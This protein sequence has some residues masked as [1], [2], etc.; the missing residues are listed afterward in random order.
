MPIPSTSTVPFSPPNR[1]DPYWIKGWT[2]QNPEGVLSDA[3]TST[4]LPDDITIVTVT[5]SYVDLSGRFFNSL[6]TFTMTGFAEDVDGTYFIPTRFKYWLSDGLLK[7]KLPAGFRY[8][9]QE[10]TPGGRTYYVT[11][12]ADASDPT[13]LSDLT[14]ADNPFA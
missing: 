13:A 10:G 1:N 3:L 2:A 9:V 8:L 11:L 12:P 5:A 7:A 4:G 14:D 6:V